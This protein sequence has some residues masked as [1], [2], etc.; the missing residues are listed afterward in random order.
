MA[1][2]P[3]ITVSSAGPLRPAQGELLGKPLDF[4]RRTTAKELGLP[5][6]VLT[7]GTGH[8]AELW[9]PGILAK[10]AW[11]HALAV[12]AP[13]SSSQPAQVVHLL[14]DTD[15][16]APLSIRVPVMTHAAERAGSASSAGRASSAGS[17]GNANSASTVLT[18]VTHLFGPA[19]RAGVVACAYPAGLPMP[20]QLGEATFAL[21]C[22]EEGVARIERALRAP[23]P[24]GAAQAWLAM[25][26]L[27]GP[28]VDSP[29]W[30]RT[31][32]LLRTTLGDALLERAQHDPAACVRAFN[33]AARSVARVARPLQHRGDAGVELPFWTWG[34]DGVRRAV[35]SHELP[36]LRGTNAPLAPRAFLTS[37][38]ARAA[39][40]SRFVHGTG[41]HIYEQ[42]TER[43]MHEWLGA[44]LP[45]FDMATATLR[46][47]F[48]TE[49]DSPVTPSIRRRAWFD[50]DGAFGGAE[51]RAGAGAEAAAGAAAA[52]PSAHKLA[53]LAA[54][55]ALPR[56]SAERRA[57][58]RAMHEELARAR[59]A[60]VHELGALMQREEEDRARV[61]EAAIRA[62]RTWAVP[63]Y[64]AEM[65]QA[66]VQRV[67]QHPQHSTA[68]A[69]A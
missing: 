55:N 48:A 12:S 35:T 21:P 47:P 62:E 43:F 25:R 19:A 1:D 63:L 45:P 33:A 27:C 38:I 53:L 41:G 10:Y 24:D 46:L 6:T 26:A 28:P 22:V 60:R 68:H 4:W 66:L 20:L 56:R 50:P 14:V 17:A 40:C 31:S 39:L 7:A 34:A 44:T 57:A 67:L 61:R 54:V 8:Q 2:A 51:A 64:P 65:V 5:D 13:E 9:H 58:W 16:R 18:T 37:A 32:A 36:A 23:A 49:H 52:G 42:A 59:E 29:A 11:A 69:T 30:T 3:V 15:V